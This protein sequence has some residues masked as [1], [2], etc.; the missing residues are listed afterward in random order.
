VFACTQQ[1]KI[2]KFLCRGFPSPKKQLKLGTFERN[3]CVR[4]AVQTAQFQAMGIISGASQHPKNV[5]FVREFWCRTYSLGAV[6]PRKKPTFWRSLPSTTLHTT[7]YNR[8][9]WGVVCKVVP[10]PLHSMG[11]WSGGSKGGAGAMAP[12]PSQRSAPHC[13]CGVHTTYNSSPWRLLRACPSLFDVSHKGA[14]CF[15]RAYIAVSPRIHCNP[16]SCNCVVL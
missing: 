5:P 8:G 1:W 14:A 13:E 3:A 15:L 6:S 11:L 4:G 2:S 12:T 9:L 10:K 7:F 16:S